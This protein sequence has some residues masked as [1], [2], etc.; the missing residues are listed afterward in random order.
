MHVHLHT[1]LDVGA[2]QGQ[3]EVI[4]ETCR[5]NELQRVSMVVPRP[6]L[7]VADNDL[8]VN[9]KVRGLDA[10]LAG[11]SEVAFFPPMTGG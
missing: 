9:Q 6:T 10:P 8:A 2:L 5:V 7:E 1:L 11:A 3:I 4:V